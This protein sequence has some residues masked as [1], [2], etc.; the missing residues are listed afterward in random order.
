MSHARLSPGMGRSVSLVDCHAADGMASNLRARA[1]WPLSLTGSPIG[2]SPSEISYPSTDAISASLVS[3]TAP[4][5]PASSLHSCDTEQPSSSA[6]WVWPTPSAIRISRNSATR[7]L[8]NSRPR[9]RPRSR[10]VSLVGTTQS[11]TKAAY[12]P[13][14]RVSAARRASDANPVRRELRLPTKSARGRL[15]SSQVGHLARRSKTGV[16]FTG[17]DLHPTQKWEREFGM[18]RARRARLSVRQCARRMKAGA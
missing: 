2:C 18:W 17:W 9:R 14:G 15:S 4:T 12:Q 6:I 10:R 11:L 13:V 16:D 5:S 8:T 1:S 3:A 7:R